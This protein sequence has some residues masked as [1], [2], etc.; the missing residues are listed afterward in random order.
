MG[1]FRLDAQLELLM[2]IFFLL[3]LFGLLHQELKVVL[4]N[5][6][7]PLSQVFLMPSMVL[8]LLLMFLQV[9]G[10]LMLFLVD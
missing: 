10:L 6:L 2:Q 1:L 4:L 8:D 5:L 7:F 3:L 9:T